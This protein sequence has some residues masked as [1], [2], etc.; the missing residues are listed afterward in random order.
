MAQTAEKVESLVESDGRMADV[1]RTVLERAED[2]AVSFADVQDE[3]D[4]GQWGR[5]IERGLLVEDG[6]EYVVRER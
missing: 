6:D 1:L 3:V 4:S 2:G 5:V